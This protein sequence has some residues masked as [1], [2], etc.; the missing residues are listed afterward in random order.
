MYQNE[1]EEAVPTAIF[2]RAIVQFGR[3]NGLPLRGLET[4]F[5]SSEQGHLPEYSKIE[6]ELRSFAQQRRSPL[7]RNTTRWF[8][9]LSQGDLGWIKAT[10][11]HGQVW[12]DDQ[13]D[14]VVGP[15]V[16]RDAY[17]T[18]WFKEKLFYLGGR[19]SNQTITIETKGVAQLELLLFEDM[20]DFAKPV[21]VMVNDRKRH[22]AII[23]PSIATL[24][25]AA[26]EK[27]EFHQLVYARL[28]FSI[29]R[30]P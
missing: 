8:R 13:L 10:K 17:I 3:Q 7:G 30:D 20:V 26:Y 28:T 23:Q 21:T 19:T 1:A 18:G 15:D 27:W 24:L 16:D 11:L 14:I 6:S 9:H 25:N 5:F 2:N 29:A 12:S 4:P 22:E